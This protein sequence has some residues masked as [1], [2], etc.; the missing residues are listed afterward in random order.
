MRKLRFLLAPRCHARPIT[1]RALPIA[2]RVAV[3]AVAAPFEPRPHSSATPLLGS[4]RH[5]SNRS[6]TPGGDRSRGAS[7]PLH[8][9]QQCIA[10]PMMLPSGDGLASE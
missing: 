5:P 4:W 7:H 8:P 6:R 2:V 1:E 9:L 3:P 10:H